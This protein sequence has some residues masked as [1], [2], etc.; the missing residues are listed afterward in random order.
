MCIDSVIIIIVK[1]ISFIHALID[2]I[3]KMLN[4]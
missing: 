1:H 2:M 3:R 4:S